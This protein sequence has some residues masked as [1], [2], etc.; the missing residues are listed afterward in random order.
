MTVHLYVKP[1]SVKCTQF[2][3][4]LCFF[5]NYSSKTSVYSHY[6]HIYTTTT[7][8]KIQP[9]QAPPPHS[10]SCNMRI[11]KCASALRKNTTS[12]SCDDHH[13]CKWSICAS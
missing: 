13:E 6:H 1:C 10:A 4:V 7:T 9:Q 3:M 5:H 8:Q 11:S 12:A 2:I